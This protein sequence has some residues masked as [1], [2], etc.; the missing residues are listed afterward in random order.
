MSSRISS[1]P[2]QILNYGSYKEI[3]GEG[4]PLSSNP[5]LKGKL[6]INFQVEF[7]KQLS[8]AQR[9]SLQKILSPSNQNTELPIHVDEHYVMEDFDENAASNEY[10]SHQS[11]YDSDDEDTDGQRQNVQCAQ[12]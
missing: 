5:F 9:Q 12:G 4:M 6:V 7:P 1:K 10:Q 11:A 3:D 8:I 2:G